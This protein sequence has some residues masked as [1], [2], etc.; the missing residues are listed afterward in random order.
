MERFMIMKQNKWMRMQA[1][2]VYSLKAAIQH[3][4]SSKLR[5]DKICTDPKKI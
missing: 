3:F 1:H 2:W 5:R 4:N